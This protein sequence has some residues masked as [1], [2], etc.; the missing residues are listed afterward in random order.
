MQKL[1]FPLL[2]VVSTENAPSMVLSLLTDVGLNNDIVLIEGGKKWKNL[3]LTNMRVR[4]IGWG[5]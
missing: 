1:P 3:M 5:L 2:F 4:F